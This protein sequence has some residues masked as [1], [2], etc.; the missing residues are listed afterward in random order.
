MQHLDEGTI[1]AWLD[2]ALDEE[3]R[4]RV[5][6]HVAACAECAGAVAEAYEMMQAERSGRSGHA[7]S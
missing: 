1:H 3:E 2:G 7:A 4:S 5:E 6:A